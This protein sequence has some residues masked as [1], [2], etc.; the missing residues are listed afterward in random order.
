[1]RMRH[2]H[3]A[4]WLFA[5][6]YASPH[7]QERETLWINIQEYGAT[8][9]HPWLFASDFNKTIS[10]EEGNHGGPDVLRHCVQ[11]KH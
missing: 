8:I 5:V 7:P 4:S 1:M 11:F 10:L 2:G 3:E 9:K 6:I